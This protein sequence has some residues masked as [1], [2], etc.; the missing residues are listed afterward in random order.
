MITPSLRVFLA[1]VLLASTSVRLPATDFTW[2]GKGNDKLWSNEKNWN[3]NDKGPPQGTDTATVSGAFLV[4]GSGAQVGEFTLDGGAQI[5]GGITIKK[6]LTW[7]A[8]TF[9][10]GMTLES[11]ATGSFTTNTLCT[12]KGDWTLQGTFDVKGGR[13]QIETCT[14]QNT[15]I[16]KCTGHGSIEESAISTKGVL[17]NT[18]NIL[19]AAGG[20]FQI[21]GLDFEDQGNCTVESDPASLLTFTGLKTN[22]FIGKFLAVQ[23]QGRLAIQ[24]SA[25]L[26]FGSAISSGF[27]GGGTA[28]VTD[29]TIVGGTVLAGTRE[30]YANCTL[31]N[32]LV[33]GECY[34]NGSCTLRGLVKFIGNGKGVFR[35]GALQLGN[36]LAD[37][38]SLVEGSNV[39]LESGPLSCGTNATITILDPAVLELVDGTIDL[40]AFNSGLNVVIFN[41]GILRRSPTT[42]NTT[43]INVGLVN[44]AQGQIIL[45]SGNLSGISELSLNSQ[46]GFTNFGSIN[47]QAN[48]QL[49][50]HSDTLLA[51]SG[52]FTGGGTVLVTDNVRLTGS[53]DPTISA[54]VKS[55]A[56]RFDGTLQIAGIFDF[57][58]GTIGTAAGDPTHITILEGGT[59]NVLQGGQCLTN[60]YL[61]IEGTVD[62]HIPPSGFVKDMRLSGNASW[63]VQTTGTLDL[64]SEGNL[65]SVGSALVNLRNLGTIHRRFDLLDDLTS[66]PHTFAIRVP[67]ANSGM[68]SV[69]Q[70]Q[71]LTNQPE[72]TIASAFV[73]SGAIHPAAGSTVLI[74]ATPCDLKSSSDLS[75]AGTFRFVAVNLQN[76]DASGGTT[77]LSINANVTL[78]SGSTLSIPLTVSGN[79]ACSGLGLN[80]TLTCAGGQATLSTIYMSQ[81]NSRLI[82]LGDTSFAPNGPGPWALGGGAQIVNRGNCTF[83]P[84]FSAGYSGPPVATFVNQGSCDVP[85]NVSL[86]VNFLMNLNTNY[87]AR[88]PTMKITGNFAPSTFYMN[89]GNVDLQNGTLNGSTEPVLEGNV[90]GTG[91]IANY[92]S[93]THWGENSSSVWAPGHSPGTITSLGNMVMGAKAILEMQIGG[94]NPGVDYDQFI[95]QG[96]INFGGGTVNLSLINGFQPTNGQTFKIIGWNGHLKSPATYNGLGLP[97]HLQFFPEVRSDG[98]YLVVALE[99]ALNP[100][101]VA[102]SGQLQLNF[103]TRAA[104]NYLIESKDTLTTTNWSFV[105]NVTGDGTDKSINVSATSP[106]QRFYRVTEQ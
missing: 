104:K 37:Q 97:N 85:N 68:I 29:S 28:T 11:G 21:T 92:L 65:V 2:T 4:D 42:A 105:Q 83:Q 84:G 56:G 66:A 79:F 64:K 88:P 80:N 101:R 34:L 44:T 94:P 26:S 27:S 40:G 82:L 51:R 24:S 41:S 72:L 47:L 5:D 15:G 32:H 62:W 38:L 52:T 77:T 14:I 103:H 49:A 22:S 63:Q 6:K 33:E 99:L 93:N 70:G 16:L 50:L 87:P 90:T 55:H 8:G 7:S 102:G 9:T 25:L 71:F 13:L 89:S 35:A 75:G 58:G 10:G 76:S 61:D 48:T 30:N 95:I 96:F 67:F 43:G 31:Q 73:N 53:G 57:D 12:L 69:D 39:K 17:N 45:E 46:F 86:P 81:S 106:K 23:G 36:V 54:K 74:A 1:V 91:N 3:P 59:M 19:C 20:Q 98:V 60:S 100:V 18:G 78:D